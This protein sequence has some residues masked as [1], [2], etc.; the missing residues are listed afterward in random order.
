MASLMASGNRAEHG[1]T[2]IGLLIFVALMAAGTMVALGAGDTLAR[3]TAEAELIAIGQEM[4]TALQRYA[5]ATPIGQP[6]EPRELVELLRDPRQ[7]GVVRHLR[8]IY[9]DPL[10]NKAEWGLLKTPEGRIAGIH[11]LSHTPV[12]RRTGF[13]PGCE[14][15][16]EATFHDEWI[17]APLPL[18]AKRIR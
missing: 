18:Q 4:R 9:P 17:F 3:R 8:R 14:I 10:T 11:S 2:Y 7:P 15:F 1:F 5:D 6:T 13:P 12:F 16:T